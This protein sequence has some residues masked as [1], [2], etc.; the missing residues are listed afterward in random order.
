MFKLAYYVDQLN[1]NWYKVNLFINID[2]RSTRYSLLI[3]TRYNTVGSIDAISKAEEN[4]RE[5]REVIYETQWEEM[6]NYCSCTRTTT[7]PELQVYFVL[8]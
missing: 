4:R 1:S 2:V 6:M 7:H 5:K 8:S 3:I